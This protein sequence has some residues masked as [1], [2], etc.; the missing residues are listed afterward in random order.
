MRAL[1]WFTSKTVITS[2]FGLAKNLGG[3]VTGWWTWAG[4]LCGVNRTDTVFFDT[5]EDGTIVFPWFIAWL[6]GVTQVLAF[7][8]MSV[9]T[10]VSWAAETG[11]GWN[12]VDNGVGSSAKSNGQW[13]F[14]TGWRAYALFLDAHA[15]ISDYIISFLTS[16]FLRFLVKSTGVVQT[17]SDLIVFASQFGIG[18]EIQSFTVVVAF[19]VSTAVSL[20]A[21][22]IN[23][24]G[25]VLVW[26]AWSWSDAS[27]CN[28]FTDFFVVQTLTEIT[29]SFWIF[30]PLRIGF[31][32]D[33]V[34]ST[35]S[36]SLWGGGWGSWASW[37][38]GSRRTSRITSTFVDFATIMKHTGN[39]W[40]ERSFSL[41]SWS[42]WTKRFVAFADLI[43]ATSFWS[44][45]ETSVWS[46]VVWSTVS[47]TIVFR[48]G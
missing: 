1:F 48:E 10:S 33:T 39:E 16:V 31:M 37:G 26:F 38:S 35:F 30:V 44:S 19:S 22:S 14:W 41:T 23:G 13:F 43:S 3:G 40:S 6:V 46:P 20:A 32:L 7:T 25:G 28:S 18:W 5:F 45:L 21:A 4:D 27:W 12:S 9:G 24:D 47:F 29:L 15:R 17:G 11:L 8:I 42:S 2:A 36:N 34:D